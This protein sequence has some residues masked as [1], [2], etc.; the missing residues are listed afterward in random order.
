MKIN[1]SFTKIIINFFFRKDNIILTLD[2]YQDVSCGADK[3]IRILERYNIY[4]KAN[5]KT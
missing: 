1:Y 3:V 4:F 5:F 2:V